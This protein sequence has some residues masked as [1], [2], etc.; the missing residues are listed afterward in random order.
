[1]YSWIRENG[2]KVSYK[3]VTLTQDILNQSLKGYE[4]Y[5][6]TNDQYIPIKAKLNTS[7]YE[8]N[9]WNESIESFT[10]N[11]NSTDNVSIPAV[12]EGTVI[13]KF[14]E[15]TIPYLASFTKYRYYAYL[16]VPN[17]T[18]AWI[19]SNPATIEYPVSD[20]TD[21][22]RGINITS[23]INN[24]V[25]SFNPLGVQTFAKQGS[26]NIIEGTFS[27]DQM[28][29]LSYKNLLN[30]NYA[31]NNLGLTSTSVSVPLFTSSKL[32]LVYSYIIIVVIILVTFL[33]WKEGYLKRW[34][35]EISKGEKKTK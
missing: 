35:Q 33:V 9:G 2:T 1:S 32:P 5:T 27:A 13:E 6:I 29:S 11:G 19:I 8:P 28:S 17:A 22:Y 4:A 24:N 16:Y 31:V 14:N 7:Q 23:S 12:G 34:I 10:I 3:N 18:R 25:I 26:V 20:F 30:L 21:L 15:T